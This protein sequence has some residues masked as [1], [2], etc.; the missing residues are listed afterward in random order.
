MTAA[1]RFKIGR[2]TF[3]AFCL[4]GFVACNR[5]GSDPESV[6]GSATAHV[7]SAAGEV[8]QY[9]LMTNAVGWLT[10]SNIVAL[11]SVVNAGPI[12]AARAESEQWTDQQVNQF[13]LEVIREHSALQASIDSLGEKRRIPSQIPAVAASMRP[14]YD[15]I[16]AKLNGVPLDGVAA[17]FLAIEDE[18]HGRTLN[19]FGALGGNATDPDLRAILAV[20]ATDMERR[21]LARAKELAKSLAEAD[22]AK[23]AAKEAARPGRKP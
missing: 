18:L 16:V 10:D 13:A 8:S 1:S 17:K 5:T 19:D 21:H 12:E 23:Q 2:A 11:A 7:D 9:S 3:A 15:S 14:Q 6:A 4:T 20:R 22:S